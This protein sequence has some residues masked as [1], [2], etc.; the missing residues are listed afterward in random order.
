MA[1]L[2]KSTNNYLAVALV[3]M[4][5]ILV[6]FASSAMNQVGDDDPPECMDTSFMLERICY[7]EERSPLDNYHPTIRLNIQNRLSDI[8]GFT[9]RVVGEQGLVPIVLF[10]TIKS[11]AEGEV[12]LPYEPEVTG[13]PKRIE[14]LPIVNLNH[15]LYHCSA[16]RGIVYQEEVPKC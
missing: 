3:F 2:S 15:N 6:F 12:R 9:V 5:I 10:K 13:V 7:S 14:I 11:G 1:I 16:A 8:N 4:L